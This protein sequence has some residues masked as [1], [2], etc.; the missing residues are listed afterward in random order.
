[1]AASLEEIR[2]CPR[3]GSAVVTAERFGRLRPIC[4]QCHWVYFADPKVAAAALIEKD[5]KVL[6]ARRANDPK[7]GLWTMPAGF[8]D[9]GEDPAKAVERECLEETGLTVQVVGLIDVLAGQEHARGAHIL[10]VYRVKILSGT[11][12]AHD[13]VDQLG[14]FEKNHLP[15]LA[16]QATRQILADAGYLK[17]ENIDNN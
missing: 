11:L 2:F 13:D 9:A 14:F 7:R 1:M 17:H 15:P 12:A 3:C 8:V 10:I 16:F 4:P 6:L 5:G